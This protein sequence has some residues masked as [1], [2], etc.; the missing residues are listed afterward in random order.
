M[1]LGEN[2]WSYWLLSLLSALSMACKLTLPQTVHI[3]QVWDCNFTRWW[4]S[5][6]SVRRQKIS[7]EN[8][9]LVPPPSLLG[10][11]LFSCIYCL[12]V[13]A[14]KLI[15]SQCSP[16]LY[17]GVLSLLTFQKGDSWNYLLPLLHNQIPPL[18]WNIPIIIQRCC[19]NTAHVLEGNKT[20]NSH[21]LS[22]YAVKAQRSE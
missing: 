16:H 7:E 4:P 15:C 8:F 22:T 14:E 18:Y 21:F 19:N 2:T 17:S 5:F 12:L 9:L 6:L 10:H 13:T 3:S 1:C 20:K 11:L